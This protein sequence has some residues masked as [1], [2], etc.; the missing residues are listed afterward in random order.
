MDI[1]VALWRAYIEREAAADAEVE[2]KI[3]D[4]VAGGVAAHPAVHLFLAR[5]GFEDSFTRRGDS[6]AH[7]QLAGCAW[8]RRCHGVSSSKPATVSLRRSL[9]L[10]AADVFACRIFQIARQRIELRFP[11]LAVVL[12][13][14]SR[15]F[16]RLGA[17]AAMM[18]AP[19]LLPCHPARV[20]PH[21]P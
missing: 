5:E 10:V 11:E 4:D 21:A 1:D 8:S 17:Q 3:L 7:F 19:V 6:A 14:R 18:H 2:L 9:A 15:V 13:P 20:F 16:H 12:D